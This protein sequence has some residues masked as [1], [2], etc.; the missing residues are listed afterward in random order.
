M[1]QGQS[2]PKIPNTTLG[3]EDKTVRAWLSKADKERA[4]E[5]SPTVIIIIIIIPNKESWMLENYVFWLITANG[6]SVENRS[7]VI[8]KIK[9]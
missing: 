7:V 5:K 1:S 4:Q 2:T 6:F 9:K 3:A 8:N